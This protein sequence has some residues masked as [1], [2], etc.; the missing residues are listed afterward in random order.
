MAQAQKTIDI[1]A[2][3]EVLYGIIVDY[4]RYP[5]FIKEMESAEIVGRNGNRVK[6]RYTLN[7]IKK[8]SYVLEHEE[9]PSR[10]LRWWLVESR[11][12]KRSDGSW[13]LEDLGDGR[14]RATYT[15]AVDPRVLVPGRIA[16]FFQGQMLNSTL[17]AFKRR[18]ESL[19][20]RK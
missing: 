6:V 14:T 3:S 20:A 7:V 18:A 4:S 15:A 5:E 9:S 17:E 13:D 19:A 12:M 10:S 1:N 2:P 16:R 11:W 8:I